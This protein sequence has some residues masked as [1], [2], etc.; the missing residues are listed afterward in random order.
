MSLLWATIA[1]AQLAAMPNPLPLPLPDPQGGKPGGDAPRSE[2][3]PPPMPV[4]LPPLPPP[5][6]LTEKPPEPAKPDR[7]VTT[8]GRVHLG[9]ILRELDGGFEFEDQTG[10]RYPIALSAVKETERAG[11]GWKVPATAT[12][13]LD[14]D[15]ARRALG[16]AFDVY[17]L[18]Q[19]RARLTYAEKALVAGLGL[20]ACVVGFAAIPGDTGKVVGTLGAI[21]AGGGG[22]A[23]GVTALRSRSLS[24]RAEEG[25]AQLKAMEQR[26]S[27]RGGGLA[28]P[29]IA[30]R[31]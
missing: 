11:E 15:A 20:L 5:S 22:I 13:T 4:L 23:L 18:E 3:V 6:S 30:L 9:R 2:P 16:L 26:T 31:F 29:A 12:P 1:A 14:A 27:A 19:E 7:I 24:R 8:D 21:G 28:L 17:A 25:R 10:A